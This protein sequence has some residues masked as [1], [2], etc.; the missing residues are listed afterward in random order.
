V[1]TTAC[2]AL[3][4]TMFLWAAAFAGS[5]GPASHS[6][7][8]IKTFL[9]RQLEAF[10]KKDISALM[11]MLAKNPHV[12]MIGNGPAN[13]WVGPKQIKKIYERQMGTYTSEMPKLTWTSIGAKG[14][15]GWF[16]ASVVIKTQETAGKKTL[17]INWSGVLQEREGKWALVQSHFSYPIPTAK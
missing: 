7:M 6:E 17:Q 3:I 9:E 5:S 1:K 11:G 16:S 10:A 8:E 13:R 14:D 12:V 2:V 15:I 4:L